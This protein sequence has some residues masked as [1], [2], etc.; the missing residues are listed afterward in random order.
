M[1]HV[2]EVI[3]ETQED[4]KVIERVVLPN[5]VYRKIKDYLIEMELLI[6]GEEVLLR[7]EEVDREC[8]EALFYEVE[9]F[10][11]EVYRRDPKRSLYEQ[12]LSIVDRLLS[13]VSKKTIKNIHYLIH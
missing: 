5:A 3:E 1:S 7:M 9:M 8:A 11:L 13:I 6:P 2:L 12:C 10:A 4:L